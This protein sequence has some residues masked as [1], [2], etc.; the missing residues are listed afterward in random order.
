[1]SS[2]KLGC[3]AC[4]RIRKVLKF[5]EYSPENARKYTKMKMAEKLKENFSEETK[6]FI[7]VYVHID[8]N[9]NH[10]PCPVIRPPKHKALNHKKSKGCNRI[11]NDSAEHVRK[12]L[13]LKKSA[14]LKG[15]D[16]S[17]LALQLKDVHEI[18]ALIAQPR[19]DQKLEDMDIHQLMSLYYEITGQVPN[20]MF[21]KACKPFTRQNLIL[22]LHL[23]IVFA[24]ASMDKQTHA[25]VRLK[26][27][28]GEF[29][30]VE[31]YD[32]DCAVVDSH[33]HCPF[34][35]KTDSYTDVSL[36]KAH[37]TKQHVDK[38]LEFSGLK[39][40][41]C[42]NKCEIDTKVIHNKTFSGGHWHCFACSNAIERRCDTFIHY[43]RH[44]NAFGSSFQ[45]HIAQDVNPVSSH[46]TTTYEIQ[47]TLHG[48]EMRMSDTDSTPDFQVIGM[49]SIPD[50]VNISPSKYVSGCSPS[51]RPYTDTGLGEHD[52]VLYVE[53]D[54]HGNVLSTYTA[55]QIPTAG[56]ENVTIS[57]PENSDVK[58]LKKKIREL[59]ISNKKMETH[60]N[61]QKSYVEFLEKTIS[62]LKEEHSKKVEK[63]DAEIE[64]LKKQLIIDDGISESLDNEEN[65]SD[66]SLGSC[67]K[68]ANTSSAVPKK[69]NIKKTNSK[70]EKKS[71]MVNDVVMDKVEDQLNGIKKEMENLKNNLCN[72]VAPGNNVGTNPMIQNPS[73]LCY[74]SN[75]GIMTPY[76][77]PHNMTGLPYINF[78][79]GQNVPMQMFQNTAALNS[80]PLNTPQNTLN[81]DLS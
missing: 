39:I 77:L 47:N 34:C 81:N 57:Y 6:R 41:R 44:L 68:P 30:P 58:Q 26:G 45:V 5:P 7:L 4:I 25:S 11:V 67:V 14:S 37:Y 76:I 72:H 22:L 10:E 18:P 21:A 16:L 13:V 80:Q 60:N 27:T 65:N 24:N 56:Q 19:K 40:L 55:E 1:M 59:E 70:T 71:S 54:E 75:Q 20:E 73:P 74:I 78:V 79:T 23:C 64:D 46:R 17:N 15:K 32:E 63:L 31:C 33:M 28:E 8:S 61:L 38:A 29:T 62:D 51:K 9:H 43:E 49:N 66:S 53:E 3:P 42:F 36:L 48:I 2:K 52:D 12:G 69:I 50:T 35:S